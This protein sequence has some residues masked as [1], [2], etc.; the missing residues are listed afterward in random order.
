MAEDLGTIRVAIGGP[1]TGGPDPTKPSGT[2]AGG[3]IGFGGMVDGKFISG[4]VTK[5]NPY[6]SA[7]M[8]GIRST[9]AAVRY[10]SSR[11]E[12]GVQQIMSGSKWSTTALVG[13]MQTRFQALQQQFQAAQIL[14]PMYAQILKWYRELMGTMQPY[15]IY[16]QAIM[17]FITGTLI[18]AVNALAP[19][20][21]QIFRA[22]VDATLTLTQLLLNIVQWLAEKKSFYKPIS[23]A[24]GGPMATLTSLWG[25]PFASLALISKG[26]SS[27]TGVLN[28]T[29]LGSAA[30]A[31]AKLQE[32]L[33]Q[34]L[35]QA[36]QINGNTKKP[37]EFKGAD[38]ISGQ[39]R[40]IASKSRIYPSGATAAVQGGFWGPPGTG[41]R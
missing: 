19:L 30:D 1:A 28:E 33:T 17:S 32:L 11:I 25:G 21:R 35:V 5:L 29:D 13:V 40:Q 39:L 12:D 27:L 3:A 15:K 6:V 10:V 37:T 14:G 9:I 4:L 26:I 38:W 24:T 7:I 16:L 8:E 34:T 22:L 20:L 36:E 2:G 31:L 41:S 18:I 23:E